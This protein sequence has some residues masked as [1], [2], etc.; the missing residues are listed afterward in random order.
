V[1]HHPA[2]IRFTGSTLTLGGHSIAANAATVVPGSEPNTV[3]TVD[4]VACV[5]CYTRKAAYEA[6]TLE[7]RIVSM[8]EQ[9]RSRVVQWIDQT[10]GD[11]R[12]QVRGTIF[13]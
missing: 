3:Y 9:H 10:G 8:S 11:G 7:L 12:L 2:A 5:L 6:A 4:A 13:F 1:A